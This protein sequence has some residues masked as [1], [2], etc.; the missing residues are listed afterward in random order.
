[1]AVSTASRTLKPDSRVRRMLFQIR[2][3]RCVLPAVIRTKRI[4][5][6]S[7]SRSPLER[8][9]PGRPMAS[10]S[11]TTPPAVRHQPPTASENPARSTSR[12]SEICAL[13]PRASNG[14]TNPFPT[15]R[16]IFVPSVSPP[17]SSSQ[18]RQA[19]RASLLRTSCR[20][21][22]SGRIHSANANRFR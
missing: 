7:A 15:A 10:R 16:Q 14:S 11:L 4:T 1:M 13:L 9:V 21:P 17:I 20:Y 6:P 3:R 12:A 18:Y 5:A 8:A 19:P 22:S 2:T